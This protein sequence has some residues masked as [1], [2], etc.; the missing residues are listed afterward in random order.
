MVLRIIL[1]LSCLII[2]TWSSNAPQR[3]IGV[4]GSIVQIAKPRLVHNALPKHIFVLEDATQ[5]QKLS[6]LCN[7]VTELQRGYRATK[8]SIFRLGHDLSWRNHRWAENLVTNIK[9]SFLVWSVAAFSDLEF[10]L[11]RCQFRWGFAYVL[12][13]KTA[14]Q[15]SGQVKVARIGGRNENGLFYFIDEQP[16]RCSRINASALVL[17]AFALMLVSLVWQISTIRP[18][19]PPTTPATV[20]QV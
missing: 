12:K 15:Q 9:P 20:V 11:P 1:L 19:Q 17:A 4:E 7:D 2:F 5:P 14:T 6:L 10:G 13:G 16:T 3:S 18:I 8:A